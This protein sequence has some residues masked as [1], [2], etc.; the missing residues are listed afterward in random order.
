MIVVYA[1]SKALLTS[2]ETKTAADYG[3]V[4]RSQPGHYFSCPH[5]GNSGPIR[6][7]DESRLQAVLDAR[8][9]MCRAHK[10]HWSKRDGRWIMTRLRRDTGGYDAGG[11]TYKNFGPELLNIAIRAT[12]TTM[13]HCPQ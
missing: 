9:H 2:S 11:F 13:L 4:Q 7:G 3:E 8:G 6:T 1:P 10:N 5:C 12:L